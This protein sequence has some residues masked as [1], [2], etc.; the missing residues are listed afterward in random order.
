MQK[1][2]ESCRIL[3]NVHIAYIYITSNMEKCVLNAIRTIGTTV[4]LLSDMVI[5]CHYKLNHT[6]KKSHATLNK[7]FYNNMNSHSKKY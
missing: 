4:N 7:A 3:Q 2:V 1:S 6:E 5:E